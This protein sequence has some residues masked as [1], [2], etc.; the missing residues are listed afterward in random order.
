L[1]QIAFIILATVLHVLSCTSNV[2]CGT[3]PVTFF[4]PVRFVSREMNPAMSEYSRTVQNSWK[5]AEP[6]LENAEQLP[7]VL[8]LR[9][10]DVVSVLHV[11]L[12]NA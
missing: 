11:Q 12:Q 5:E 8:I 3:S 4:S 9:E 6:S 10:P 2:G 7:L 1:C